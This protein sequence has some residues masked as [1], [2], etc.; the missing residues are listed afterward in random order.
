MADV[1][2]DDKPDLIFRDFGNRFWISLADGGGLL[3]KPVASIGHGGPFRDG[4]VFFAD[5]NGDKR[6][7]LIFRGVDNRF[8][9]SLADGKGG[10]AN[11]VESI[12]HG[13]PF[14]EDQV[15]FADVNGDGRADLIFRG[16]D[17]RF[18][19]SL[20]D[21]KG[22][23]ANPVESI[24]HGG[25][26]LDG[27]VFFADI[28]GDKRSD[29]IFRGVDNRFWISLANDNGGLANP[30]ESIRHGGSYLVDQVSLA[31]VN[32][33]GRADLVF[34]GQDSRFWISLAD[35]KGGL[36]NPVESI[37]HGGP[38]LE[39]QVFFADVNGDG[40]ADLIFRGQDSRFWISLADGK[41]G[42][43]N[44]VESIGHGG[45]FL[46]GQ[47]FFADIN[48]DKRSDL[49]FRGVDNRFWISL[50]NDNGGLANPVESV[51]P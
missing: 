23:L 22:G 14:L 40:R 29:L 1:N 17:S 47:V 45:P 12:R 7:D 35:G 28:N 34:R 31:D 51:R 16:Q 20:A 27:Q 3:A 21:G 50:A 44:P 25:P 37:R 4:Q 26:F 30:V 8:W 11:P 24:G 41:G 10:L 6:S 15:F 5:I 33:D 43:A 49:I 48:G 9:I 39:D 18:W 32:G 42:L 2:G 38:F 13:G 36:A 19:I 46:D